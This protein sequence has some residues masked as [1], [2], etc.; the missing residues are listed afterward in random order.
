MRMRC[1]LTLLAIVGCGGSGTATTSSVPP[2]PT[3][4]PTPTG[5]TVTGRVGTGGG[6]TF[7][8]ATVTINAGDTVMWVWD[9]GLHTVTSGAPGAVDGNFCSLPPGSTPSPSACDTVAYAQSTG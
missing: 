4:A 2:A 5:N 7:T 8:P 9:S 3:P 6:M 1:G